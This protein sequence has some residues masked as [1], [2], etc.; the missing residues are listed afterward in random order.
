MF[1]FF[2]SYIVYFRLFIFHFS[3]YFFVL[4]TNIFDL[5]STEKD[6]VNN[7][8]LLSVIYISVIAFDK[9]E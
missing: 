9:Y 4:S 6:A 1:T 8:H 3:I 2:H 7:I 5:P